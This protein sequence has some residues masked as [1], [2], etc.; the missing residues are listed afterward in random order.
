MKSLTGILTC[1]IFLIGF[2]F[3]LYAGVI[4]V[5]QKAG[6]ANDSNPGSAALPLAT[7]QAGAGLAQ[8]GDT[9]LVKEGIYRERVIPPRGGTEGKPITFLAAS[10]ENV[11]I[12]GSER[13]TGW[14][15]EGSGLWTVDIENTFFGQFNPYC[16]NV[17]GSWL[18]GKET[19]NSKNIHHLGDVYYND[20]AFREVF[21][22][23]ECRNNA[24]T[25]YTEQ[26][27]GRT[28]LYANF[29]KWNPNSGCTEINV[30]SSIIFPEIT[31]LDYIVI[32]GFDIRHA[33]SQWSDTYKL[34]QGGIGMKYGYR[35]IIQ[36]CRI[37]DCRNNGISMGVSDEINFPDTLSEGGKNIPPYGTFG[38]HI[39]RN[40]IIKRCGQCGIYGC[41]GAVGTTIEGNEITETLYRKEWFGPNQADIKILFPIDVTIRNNKFYGTGGTRKAIWLDWGSQNARIT[42]NLIIDRWEGVF[43]EVS[44]GPTI[45]DNNLFIRSGIR[46]W[47]DGNVYAHNLFYNSTLFHIMAEPRRPF[48]PYYRAHSTKLAGRNWT[49]QRHERWY[50]NIFIGKKVDYDTIEIK[51]EYNVKTDYNLYYNDAPAFSVEGKNSVR[52]DSDLEFSISTDVCGTWIT[53]TVQDSIQEKTYP[54]ITSK[55]VGKSPLPKSRMENKDGSGIKIN[56]DYCKQPILKRQVIPGPFQKLK[57]GVNRIK[58]WPVEQK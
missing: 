6:N 30:R 39:I 5:S 34:E 20:E 25:W 21:S 43:T 10:G 14:K 12:R 27:N 16:T 55:M 28:S 9:V 3:S 49:N 11:S 35:W 51:E 7:I 50:N 37:S 1:I 18:G 57:K 52:S 22:I 42:G 53:F 19:Q 29:S 36:N 32:D 38:F 41:Y 8:P 54:Y 40:N 4:H 2:P 56:E 13:M 46:D 24:K 17:S 44:F 45:I 48:V 58:V 26:S 23:E 31:G 47:S 15:N 33:A